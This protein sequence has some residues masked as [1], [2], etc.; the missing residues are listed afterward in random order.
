MRSLLAMA[1]FAIGC[2][3]F[4]AGKYAPDPGT[5]PGEED[6][7]DTGGDGS[8]V[9][10]CDDAPRVDWINFGQGFF[11]QN[12]NGCHHSETPDRYGAPE[13]VIFDTADDVWAQ[14]GLVLGTAGGESP[15]MPPNGGTTLIQ[16]EKLQIWLECGEDG[17]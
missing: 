12:C 1:V 10:N 13:D 2:D 17:S 5:P 14:K 16:R 6:P 3:E 4:Y 7:S 8:D 9:L 11:V 15:S